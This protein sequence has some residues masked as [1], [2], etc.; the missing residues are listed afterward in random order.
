MDHLGGKQGDDPLAGP[1]HTDLSGLPPLIIE[2]GSHEV[3]R[4]DAILFG[5]AARAQSR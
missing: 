1:A 2:V 3:L 4:D 5:R